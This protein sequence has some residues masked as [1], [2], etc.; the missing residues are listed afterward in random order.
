MT[1]DW[2]SLSGPQRLAFTLT[3][4]EIYGWTCCLC[5]LPI[6]GQD[7]LSCEHLKARSQGGKTTVENCRPA[8]RSCNYSSGALIN[9][10]NVIEHD[11]LAFFW[12]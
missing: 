12:P 3:L 6:A 4:T 9:Q 11:G 10:Q 8:H 2:V 7:E 5:S 1:D